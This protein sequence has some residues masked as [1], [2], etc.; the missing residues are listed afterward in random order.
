MAAWPP[1]EFWVAGSDFLL[2]RLRWDLLETTYDLV[3]LDGN[4]R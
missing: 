2:L 3:A 1:L 4:A